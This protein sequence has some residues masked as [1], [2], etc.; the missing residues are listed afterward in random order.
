MKNKLYIPFVL[1]TMLFA[2]NNAQAQ[3]KEKAQDAINTNTH[4]ELFV[5]KE[6]VKVYPTQCVN[7]LMIDNPDE[8][9]LSYRIITTDGKEVANGALKP[10]GVSSINVGGYPSGEYLISV[11]N[12]GVGNTYRFAKM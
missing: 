3:T 11:T 12:R 9:L 10:K 1:V 5:A 7:K 8:S 6:T 4:Q 2:A